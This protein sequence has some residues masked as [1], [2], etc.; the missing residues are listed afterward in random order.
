M[1]TLDTHGRRKT[2][3]TEDINILL[4]RAG[5]EEGQVPLSG[6]G[7]QALNPTL[8]VRAPSYVEAVATPNG[9]AKEAHSNGNEAPER[10]D[11][12]PRPPKAPVTTTED[13]TFW[14]SVPAF[15]RVK[16]NGAVVHPVERWL[17][18][19]VSIAERVSYSWVSPLMHR[20]Q[21]TVL[22]PEDMAPIPPTDD[23]EYLANKLEYEWKREQDRHGDKANIV[24]AYFRAFRPRLFKVCM[25]HMMEATFLVLQSW[26]LGK[27]ILAIEDD[28]ADDVVY[29]YSAAL[30]VAFFTTSCVLH[31]FAFMEGW[32]FG[33]VCMAATLGAVYR[34]SLRLRQQDMAEISSGFVLN[35]ITNDAER[36]LQACI[37]VPFVF[38]GPLMLLAATLLVWEVVGWPA[39]CGMA[40]LVITIPIYMLLSRKLKNLRNK[41]A[42]ITDSRVKT[43]SEVLSGMRVLKMNG[44]INPFR[45]LIWNIRTE[46]IKAL[47][48]VAQIRGFQYGLNFATPTILAAAVFLPYVIATD[49]ELSERVVFTTMAL[50]NSVRFIIGMCV[51]FSLQSIAEMRVVFSRIN[52]MLSMKESGSSSNAHQDE[53]SG[54]HRP[55]GQSAISLSDV[56]LRWSAEAEPVLKNASFEVVRGELVMVVGPVGSGKTALLMAI[57]NELLP[58]SG[59]I[60][61]SGTIAYAPQEAWI[62]SDTVRAN[63]LFGE[64]YRKDQYN[65]VIKMCQL[66]H[67]FKLFDQGDMTF[68]GERG[69]TLSG[70]QRA[71]IGLARAVYSERDIFVLDDPLS[72]VDAKVG[73]KI[74]EECLQGPLLS[75][76]TRILVTHQLQFASRADKIVVL[77]KDHRITACGSHQELSAQGIDFTG[78]V[79]DGDEP[80]SPTVGTRVRTIS[81]SSTTSS[82]SLVT[83][84]AASA[85]KS[86]E[87]NKSFGAS[88]PKKE[89]RSSGVVT[90]K[91]YA[92]YAGA[93]FG[94]RVGT[95][96]L[97]VF[98]LVTQVSDIMTSWWLAEWADMSP[99]DQ[100]G[101]TPINVYGGLIASTTV[102]SFVRA[103]LFMLGA[104]RAATLLH[105]RALKAVL[106]SPILFFDTTPVGTILNKF[107]KD[108][109]YVDDLLPMTAFD[110]LAGAITVVAI[111]LLASV[112][113]PYIFLVS[114]PLT[115]I[116]FFL[117]KY[118][119]KASREI[120][121]VEAIQRSPKYGLVQSSMIGLTTIRS[122][123]AN[124]RFYKMMAKLQNAHSQAYLSFILTSR[125]LGFRLDLISTVFITAVTFVG[126]A[127]RD[128]LG[129]GTVGLS[130]IYCFTLSGLFQ[131][132]VRQSAEVENQMISVE[133][134][135]QLNSL[136]QEHDEGGP[137][138]EGWPSS[139]SIEFKNVTMRYSEDSPLVLRGLNFFIESGEKIGIVGRT[140]AGKS[141][142]MEVL[143]RL[144]PHGGAILLDNVDTNTITMDKLRESI[145]VIPQEPLLFSGS[146]RFN[147]DP[148]NNYTDDRI[149]AAIN[150]VQLTSQL[151][152]GLETVVAENG[153][154][155]SVGQRQ[156]I[157]LARA[158]LRSNR[159]LILDEATANIDPATDNIIQEVIRERFQDW[160][161][162]TIAHRLNTVIDSD[163]I[164]VLDKGGVAEFGPPA[165]LRK[166]R[167]S[168]FAELAS[169]SQ[170]KTST[171][172]MP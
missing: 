146:I 103:A 78:I 168:L 160:T 45:D 117:R 44:W 40:F 55:E 62:L 25:Y 158:L 91:T 26:L 59:K 164:L 74:F 39:F 112:L 85:A 90:F 66:E 116:F 48:Q 32:R 167:G 145:S 155:F 99:E 136:E 52:R 11:G 36:F 163:K 132:I 109:G 122:R 157:C 162:L 72:A 46:E 71:R 21:S 28:S 67:D 137:A 143:F 35:L 113:N 105:N 37:F 73:S 170:A 80:Q 152:N 147:I 79:L 139:G 61:V 54:L 31:H 56:T 16:R 129:S 126:V 118:Y 53:K 42:S 57:L 15:T 23:A 87:G 166:A 20:A 24:M 95:A 47:R 30:V 100:D 41:I 123:G 19:P 22:G 110:F 18:S 131:W 107:S 124:D 7:A 142:L 17:L 51:P 141:T 130:L 169:H 115:V 89:E 49:G 111:V 27:L 70:G 120:K 148:F 156:L 108:I 63:I 76:K 38:I 98:M 4:G 10:H 6:N 171:A 13:A 154:N 125:W 101:P 14:Y 153:S 127:L 9:D 8:V 3:T 149:W 135:T 150:D 165:R 43:M 133:R 64:P 5:T 104:I 77:D 69:V 83:K 84:P 119:L 82:T 134:I 12:P 2:T 114:V 34:K 81:T 172:A 106:G 33:Q 128:S 96:I 121:R 138:P 29:G 97:L 86:G 140:G 1:D 93:G 92:E 144:S 151:A 60:R 161:V 58:E 65:K 88:G 50:F 159:F 102:L 94:N 68:V 75:T